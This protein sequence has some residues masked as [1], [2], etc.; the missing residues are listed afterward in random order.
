MIV[1]Q[2]TLL[3]QNQKLFKL[4]LNYF[5]CIFSKSWRL[6]KVSSTPKQLCELTKGIT[7]I[8]SGCDVDVPTIGNKSNIFP[9]ISIQIWLEPELKY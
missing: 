8:W 9:S 1:K 3:E 4:F 5:I 6:E 2:C 7:N